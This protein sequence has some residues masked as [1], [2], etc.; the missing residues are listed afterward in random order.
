M[1]FALSIG[2]KDNMLA[3][4]NPP[5]KS[6]KR[7]VTI[8]QTGSGSRTRGTQTRRPNRLYFKSLK[9]IEAMQDKLLALER[10]FKK[11]LGQYLVLQKEYSRMKINIS[12]MAIINRRMAQ[13]SQD[14][15]IKIDKLQMAR[16]YLEDKIND[17]NAK[18]EELTKKIEESKVES[19][20]TEERLIDSETYSLAKDTRIQAIARAVE[21]VKASLSWGSFTGTST[22]LDSVCAHHATFVRCFK[23][24]G[25]CQNMISSTSGESLVW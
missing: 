22:E 10:A 5:G 8:D 23:I 17:Q 15:E 13:D 20:E 4:R 6:V 1:S 11:V 25:V 16:I 7:R 19:K 21:D 3:A 14:N 12:T 9:T 24:T 18:I 2:R